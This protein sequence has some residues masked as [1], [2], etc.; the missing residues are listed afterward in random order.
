MEKRTFVAEF[1]GFRLGRVVSVCVNDPVAQAV[2]MPSSPYQRSN[3]QRRYE[4][5]QLT[6]SAMW[7][8]PGRQLATRLV[9]SQTLEVCRQ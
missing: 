9:I 2:L 3:A 1:D 7:V 6:Q 8:V 5:S 4:Q